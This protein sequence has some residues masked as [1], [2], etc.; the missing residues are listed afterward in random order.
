MTEP[1][2]AIQRAK[3]V[4]PEASLVREYLPASRREPVVSPPSLTGFLDP[5]SFDQ[6]FRLHAVKRRIKG[7]D[8][9]GDGALGSIVDELRDLVA[10]AV[11]F[12]QKR[13][14]QEFRAPALEFTL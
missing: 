5:P 7:S 12:F 6:T 2:D 1:C 3:E 10:M 11:S 13:K 9:E 8:V 4:L 14:D